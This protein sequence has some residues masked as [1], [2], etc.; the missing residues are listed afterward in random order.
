MLKR[1]RHAACGGI[2]LAVA[3]ASAPGGLPTAQQ[4]AQQKAAIDRLTAAVAAAG[5]DAGKL[6]AFEAAAREPS[7]EVRRR[8]LDLAAT[9]LPRE[10]DRE[11][12]FRSVLGK[13]RDAGIRAHA[14]AALGRVG[15]PASLPA[16]VLAA[17]SDPETQREVGC[18]V[19]RGTARRDAMF[20]LA[21]LAE[22]FPKSS[23][24]VAADLR[25]LAPADEQDRHAAR[26]ALYRVTR[27]PAVLEPV[28]KQLDDAEPARRRD[29]IVQLRFFRLKTAPPALLK[30]A[31]DA[32]A[33][34]QSWV[35]LTLGEI[36]DAAAVP[37]LAAA[38]SDARRDRYIRANA[39]ASLGRMKGADAA[40]VLRKL[41]GDPDAAVR[42]QAAAALER[43][44]LPES[45]S[46]RT[47]P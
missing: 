24:A 44:R 40:P 42:A 33:E 6:A 16:L 15:T 35:A 26:A 11:A 38:A 13:D 19:S 47:E 39:I 17:G 2:L 30:R 34:V 5:D 4:V 46:P 21:D 1:L 43:V 10:G 31:E 23:D 37:A 18:I 7:V 28:L 25:K 22:R 14:A 45:P 32:D 12:F 9:A 27:D 20:A 3:C 29:A 41:T 8:V 36:G